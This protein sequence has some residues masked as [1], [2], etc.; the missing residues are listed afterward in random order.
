VAEAQSKDVYAAGFNT[1]VKRWEKRISVGGGCAKKYMFLSEFEYH[2]F[3]DLY[4]FVAYLL[5]LP[6]ITIFCILVTKHIALQYPHI[7]TW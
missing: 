2:M 6:H 1:Q 4:P 3:Y 7:I 5:T